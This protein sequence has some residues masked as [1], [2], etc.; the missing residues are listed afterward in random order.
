MKGMGLAVMTGI[1]A[2]VWLA[3]LVVTNFN[4]VVLGAGLLVALS[5]IDQGAGGSIYRRR[6][7]H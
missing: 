4:G 3:L 6:H 7:G 1:A 5:L 2:C